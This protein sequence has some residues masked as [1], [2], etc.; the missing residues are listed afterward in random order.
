MCNGVPGASVCNASQTA[1]DFQHAN[2]GQR[3]LAVVHEVLDLTAPGALV[4]V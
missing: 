4:S 1:I 2:V 3:K